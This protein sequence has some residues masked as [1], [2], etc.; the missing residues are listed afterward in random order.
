VLQGENPIVCFLHGFRVAED[1]EQTTVFFLIAIK[2][3]IDRANTSTM[4]SAGT[5]AIKWFDRLTTGGRTVF[6]F[7]MHQDLPL[8]TAHTSPTGKGLAVKE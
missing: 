4:L 8:D 6:A 7:V 2:I 1:A 5:L 3:R